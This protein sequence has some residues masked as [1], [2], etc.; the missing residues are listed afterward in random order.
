MKQK[1]VYKEVLQLLEESGFPF[2][3]INHQPTRTAQ[4]AAK[5]S[6]SKPHEVAKS[7]VLIS[8]KKPLLVIAAGDQKINMKKLKKLKRIKDLRFAN[9]DEVIQY[10]GC[11]IGSVPPFASLLGLPLLVDSI[12]QTMDEVVFSPGTNT[13]SVR[14]KANDFLFLLEGEMFNFDTNKE[15]DL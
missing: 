15:K 5:V 13:Q 10:S 9:P 4:E 1:A 11:P 12:L 3:L 7:L 8:D 6:G 2:R 14:M